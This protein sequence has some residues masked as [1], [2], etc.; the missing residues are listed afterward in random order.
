MNLKQKIWLLPLMALL[1]FTLGVS[2]VAWVS[3]RTTSQVGELGSADYPYMVGM[4]QFNGQL[5]AFVA[6]L[7]SAVAEADK[8]RLDDAVERAGA[9]RRLLASIKPLQGKGEAIAQLEQRFETYADTAL[10]ASRILLREKTGDQTEA[11]KRMQ[12]A[13]ADLTTDVAQKQTQART[14]VDAGIVSV[15]QGVRS[16]LWSMIG[17]AVAVLGVLGV[18]SVL[19]TRSIWTQIGGE[20]EY[21]R[22]VLQRLAKGDLAQDI[23]VDTH[24]TDSL[25]G[26]MK[27]MMSSLA[28][29]VSAVRQGS[30]AMA[31]ASQQ[32][33]VGN[34]D[35][36]T[37]T[38]QAASN[39]QV[40]ANSIEQLTGTVQQSAGSAQTANDL[41]RVAADVAARGGRV[42]SE[43]VVT[44]DEINASSKKIADI[45]GVI[46][47]FAFQTSILALNAAVE[48]A[49]AGEQGRGFAVVAS[50]VRVLANRSAAA[51]KEI[52]SLIGSSVHKV[53]SGAELV[54]DA[55]STM[56]EIVASVQRVT[57]IIGLITVASSAQS[58]G[59]SR[60][61]R[62]VIQLD[63]MTQQN[64]AM[65]EESTIATGSLKDQ[66]ER[67]THTMAVFRLRADPL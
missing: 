46:D 52:K 61:N 60:L 17:C 15:Q 44:M 25:L 29:I 64:A 34:Q 2:L 13:F 5:D 42:V 3:A 21:A 38:E 51:A 50:E 43:M 35:L 6:T 59:I 19:L 62:N 56:Q 20:P 45:I 8:K 1:I 53:E 27:D 12:A 48:A 4:T 55:G 37:R 9:M 40:T 23:R 49:R 26:A 7:Q 32:I 36:S 39:L 30:D 57:D 31:V 65:V 58:A 18:G 11:V 54:T 47:G 66:A 63:Q 33:A 41:V 28:V 16:N 14:G 10:E 24:R 22:Q 67:L